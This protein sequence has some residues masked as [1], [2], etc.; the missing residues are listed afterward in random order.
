MWAGSGYGGA[1]EYSETNI[2]SLLDG[3]ATTCGDALHNDFRRYLSF[4][5]V[6]AA[7]Y[8]VFGSSRISSLKD[9]LTAQHGGS[10]T[11]EL[12]ARGVCVCKRMCACVR[13]LERRWGCG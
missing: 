13:L 1:I 5:F 2:Q 4:T 11:D 7:T 3:F 12:C 10:S 6:T 9:T 8:E